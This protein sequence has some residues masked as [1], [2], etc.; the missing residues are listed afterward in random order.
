MGILVYLESEMHKNSGGGGSVQKEKS[1]HEVMDGSDIMELVENDK[2]FSNFIDHKFEELDI[3]CDGKLS[4]KELK[5]AVQD[6]GA[7][8]GLPA[9]GT[10]AESDHIY[11]EVL[12]SQPPFV[13]ISSHFSLFLFFVFFF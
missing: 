1:S 10:S 3:D 2:V 5:P 13:L 12:I 8:L 6:I 4:V 7:A 11:T 9:Q